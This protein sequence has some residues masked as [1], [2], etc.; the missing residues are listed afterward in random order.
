MKLFFFITLISSCT[1]Y[2]AQYSNPEEVEIL[3]DKWNETDARK[4]AE[5]L[6]NAVIQKPW[7]Y[8][9]KGRYNKKPVVVVDHIEN[10][11]SE[12]IDSKAFEGYITDELINSGKI[13]FINGEKREKIL[14]EIQYQNNSGMVSKQTA[15]RIGHQIGANF[16]MSGS[17]S[18]QV[19]QRDGDKTVTYQTHLILTNLETTEIIWSQ[20]H[21][22]KKR[23][24]R[25]GLGW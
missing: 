25:S 18:S 6:I 4:T 3:D 20:K 13:R 11:T 8:E 22:I 12:H 14:K 19:H 5:I 16:M 23:F 17:I 9:F 2:Q 7:I 24:Q 15:G 1:T 21:L 10:R